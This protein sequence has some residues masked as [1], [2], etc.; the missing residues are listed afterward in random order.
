MGNY[1]DQ[2]MRWTTLHQKRDQKVPKFTNTLHTLRT[3][4]SIK[5]SKRHMV[6]KY[7][8]ALH[9]YIQTKMEF[10]DISSLGVAYRYVVQIQHKLNK[11]NK[12][13]FRSTNP[14]KPK[15][16]IE[17]PNSQ[18]NQPQDNQSKP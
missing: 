15:Y 10:Q 7:Y 12:W 14:Q 13:E 17:I 6:L 16:G 8:G 11:Q 4:L 2:Y 5:D 18:N 1:D 3:K 9:K